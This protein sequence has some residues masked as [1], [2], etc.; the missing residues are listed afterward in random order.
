MTLTELIKKSDLSVLTTT[1]IDGKEVTDCYVCDLFSL[2]MSKVPEGSAWITVQANV[3][4]VAVAHLTGASC[5]IIAE[6][7]NVEADV[8]DR[9]NSNGIVILRTEKS[10]FQMAME[11][12]YLL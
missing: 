10:A 5:V 2:A 12:G 8:V 4:I 7:M 11:I 3:N 1:A 6:N 9:A